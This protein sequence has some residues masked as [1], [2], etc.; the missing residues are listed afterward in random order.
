MCTAVYVV[1]QNEFLYSL[2]LSF[3]CLPGLSTYDSIDELGLGNW[4]PFFFLQDWS[5]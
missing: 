3:L 4:T 5:S 1:G 2:I